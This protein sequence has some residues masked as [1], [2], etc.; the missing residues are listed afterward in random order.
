MSGLVDLSLFLIG[1]SSPPL[2]LPSCILILLF[3]GTGS[4]LA[5]GFGLVIREGVL[6]LAP[7]TLQ[8]EA[9][10]VVSYSQRVNF[11]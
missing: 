2:S 6:A 8:V 4:F 9:A 7:F 1:A 10:L 11:Y 3:D 5:L